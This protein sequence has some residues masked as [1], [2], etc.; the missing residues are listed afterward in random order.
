MESEPASGS[1]ET[2]AGP[3]PLWRW[4]PLV[5]T[6]LLLLAVYT[7]SLWRGDSPAVW[8]KA[9][10]V[11]AMEPAFADTDLMGLW[12]D[13]VRQG[14]NPAQ[15]NPADPMER[16]INYPPTIYV[17]FPTGWGQAH[18]PVV[19]LLLAL[20]YLGIIGLLAAGA[21]RGQSIY[22]LFL[23]CAPASLLA[24]ERGNIDILILALAV[25]AMKWSHRPWL[26]AAALLLAALWKLFPVAGLGALL[27]GTR[28]QQIA[29]AAA[30]LLCL[31]AFWLMKD[32][33]V[34]IAG[35]LSRQFSIALGSGTIG[36]FWQAQG[37]PLGLAEDI[38]R[39]SRPAAIFLALAAILAGFLARTGGETKDA[40]RI[41]GA[42][43]GALL[44]G[45]LF[46]SGVQFDYKLLFLWPMVPWVW[47]LAGAGNRVL[48]WP[49]RVWLGCLLLSA[50]WFFF[51]TDDS[52]RFFLLKQSLTWSL[53][54]LTAFF[55]GKLLAFRIK[56][57]PASN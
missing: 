22:W 19:G 10:G 27:A 49:A 3:S 33:L 35:S 26:A 8:W 42:W 9:M 25:V 21:S 50:W 47:S 5:G 45:I 32:S 54:L 55:G 41:F 53:F 48:R 13:I 30:L 29:G 40:I 56:L 38:L 14:G 52:W 37:N 12:F 39:W 20:L 51:S 36:N 1:E 24:V 31:L 57:R 15:G 4:L 23:A 43:L 17:F 28:R 16:T 2:G 46:V 34:V 44:F 7:G 6:A 18:T 11:P